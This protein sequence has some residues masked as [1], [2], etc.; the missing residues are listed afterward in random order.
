LPLIILFAGLAIVRVRGRRP[1]QLG[2]VQWI[3]IAA[4]LSIGQCLALYF[5]MRRFI[6]GNAPGGVNLDAAGGWWW[7]IPIPPLVVFALG[8]L[9]YAATVVLLLRELNRRLPARGDS[10]SEIEQD[11]DESLAVV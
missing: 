2:R 11:A 10:T 9:A 6:N 7:S 8:S 5:T 1:L 3:A 4:T